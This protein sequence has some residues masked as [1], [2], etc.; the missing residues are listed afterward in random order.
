QLV[1]QFKPAVVSFHFGLP[2]ACLLKRVK[3]TGAKVLS[4]ATTVDEALWLEDHGSDAIIAMGYE[5][6]GHG[7]MGV[8]CDLHTQVRTLAPAQQAVGPVA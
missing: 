4:S 3:A 8:S 1:E 7:G 5:A 6:G 2:E